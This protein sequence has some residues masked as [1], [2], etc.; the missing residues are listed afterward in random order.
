MIKPFLHQWRIYKNLLAEKL[1]LGH[2]Y[3]LGQVI[4]IC[5]I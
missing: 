4:R 2:I 3:I 1:E 5:Q